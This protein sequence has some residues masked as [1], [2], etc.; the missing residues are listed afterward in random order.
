MTKREIVR[1]VLDHEKPPYVPWSY[2]F[3]KEAKAKLIDHYGDTD[4]EKYL[5][6]HILKLGS[7]IGFFEELGSNCVKDVDELFDDLIEIGLDCFNPFQP[8]VMDI[9][10]L[11]RQYRGK[12]TFHGGLSTQRTLPRG[13]AND[14]R[15]ET[16]TLLELGREGSYIFS[17]AHDVLKD[18]P[19]EN[20]LAFIEIVQAQRCHRER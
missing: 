11:M 1:Q 8:E 10:S 16:Q 17:P 9:F 4:L 2:A 12:L 14:V 5:D 13:S 15:R 3:T 7:D 6:K 18:V 19:V 20:M